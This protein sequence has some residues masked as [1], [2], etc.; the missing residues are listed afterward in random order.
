MIE[1]IPIRSMAQLRAMAPQ[2][3][4]KVPKRVNVTRSTTNMSPGHMKAVVNAA[5]IESNE[6]ALFKLMNKNNNK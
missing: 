6:S 1:N 3:P 2:S 4:D 5:Y